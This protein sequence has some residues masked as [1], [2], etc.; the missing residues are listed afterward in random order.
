MPRPERGP[1]PLFVLVAAA[2]V[3][4]VGAGVDRDEGAYDDR[5]STTD[6]PL[7]AAVAF[8]MTSAATVA[9]VNPRHAAVA[10]CWAAAAFEVTQG[11]VSEKDMAASC[12][13]AALAWAWSRLT[14]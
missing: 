11:S 8:S 7:H 4:N 1:G 10:I 14:R 3:V 13:G 5:W 2:V 6:K 12:G 9:R